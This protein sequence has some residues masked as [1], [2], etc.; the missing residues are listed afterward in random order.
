MRQLR[1]LR[2][3]LALY[4]QLRG[5]GECDELQL[6]VYSGRGEAYQRHR[7]AIPDDAL[8]SRAEQL[9]CGRQRRITL[10]AYLG[11][12]TA[13]A[14]PEGGQ[15]RLFPPSG[16]EGEGAPV[17]IQPRPRRL[18]CFLSGAIDHEVRPTLAFRAAITA[19]LH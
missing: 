18:V 16:A 13:T 8:D 12:D 6:A 15:L 17:D 2:E 7:D 9:G 10:V 14:P 19:W 4:A 11:C 3:E 1:A 5:D